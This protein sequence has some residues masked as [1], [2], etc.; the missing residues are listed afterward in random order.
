MG[1]FDSVRPFAYRHPDKREGPLRRPACP[2]ETSRDGDGHA[3]R[4]SR[5]CSSS[6][7]TLLP[8]QHIRD[9]HLSSS[10]A[11]GSLRRSI[12]I[13]RRNARASLDG[14]RPGPAR[15]HRQSL[16]SVSSHARPHRQS[17]DSVST[18]ARPHR[19]SLDSVSSPRR[20]ELQLPP[21]QNRGRV[22]CICPLHTHIILQ[23]ST[24]ILVSNGC[25]SRPSTSAIY[26]LKSKQSESDCDTRLQNLGFMWMPHPDSVYCSMQS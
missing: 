16:D 23:I 20:K 7:E 24:R 4:R 14:L 19:Q 8:L 13:P 6:G 18:P 25:F 3:G 10:V 5:H 2:G 12:D 22:R 26:I 1:L 17:L 21:L 15:P 11:R 9:E